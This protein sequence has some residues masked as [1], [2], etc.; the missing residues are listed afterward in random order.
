MSKVNLRETRWM[1]GE[2]RQPHQGFGRFFVPVLGRGFVVPADGR[3]SL[4]AFKIRPQTVLIDKA[5]GY[6]ITLLVTRELILSSQTSTWSRQTAALP[7]S[8]CFFLV[9]FFS[10]VNRVFFLP[11]VT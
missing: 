2:R 4:L 8:C 6:R 9:C 3:L 7:D 10:P 1:T 5:P 11:T